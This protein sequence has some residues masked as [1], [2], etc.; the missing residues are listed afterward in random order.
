MASNIKQ[1]AKKTFDLNGKTYTYY[2]LNTL[3]EQGFY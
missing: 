3:E 1:Q 2:D